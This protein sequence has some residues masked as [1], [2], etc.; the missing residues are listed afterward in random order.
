L[1]VRYA[2][3]STR[4]AVARY[5][6][7]V[8]DSVIHLNDAQTT[9]L[10]WIADGCP[11]GV[12]EGYT[13]RVSAA[14]LRS[15]ALV[16]IFGKGKKW[17]VELTDLGREQL[18]RLD[19]EPYA[20][21]AA[22]EVGRVASAMQASPADEINAR[23]EPATRTLSRTEQLV[24]DVIAAGG[25]LT[26]PDETARGGVNWRQRA[27]AAQRHGKVPA[28]KHLS[29]SWT[30]T[31]FEIVLLDGDTGNELNADAVPVPTRLTRY[32]R[33]AQEFRDRT[34]L[35][36]VSRKAL[37]RVLRIVHALTK[38]AERRGYEVACIRVREDSYGRSEWKPDKDGQLVFTING[39]ELKVRIW[40]KGSGLR[41]PYEHQKKRWQ[42][43]REQP[44]RLMSFVERPKPY[45]TNATGEL[46]IEALGWS[47]GRQS[48]WGDRKR[49]TLEDRLPQ[50]M[51]E[52]ETQ[53]AEAEERRLAK[54]REEAER[55]R[56][57]EAAMDHAKRRLVEDHRLEV[58]RQRVRA[59]QEAD[60]IRAYCDA[61]EACHGNDA[62]A[63]DPEV[64]Q[65]LAL[66]RER[67]DRA[68]QLPRLPA[69]P[70]I[71]HEALK[72]YLGGWSPYGPHR[73]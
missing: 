54:E 59:W 35:H 32:H 41:G 4:A 40:E 28:G 5:H 56:Q 43:D 66:A 61:V 18:E 58:L 71:T 31:G 11:P 36:E 72:P 29:V 49:W 23:E 69:D 30:N 6:T 16:R 13:H 27:Y 67:A 21:A 62:I 34:N 68:Q 63:A 46:N 70:E 2:R 65:W 9:V 52:L 51:R 26:L 15:R 3:L 24:A 64:A 10:R 45:D 7:G 17:R 19:R 12:M 25:R 42:E 48:S 57:W 22:A 60:A 20:G 47:K 50:L 38:E 33:V 1:W 37:P 44:Y 39:H 8:R 14:A 55:E 73:W 53:A